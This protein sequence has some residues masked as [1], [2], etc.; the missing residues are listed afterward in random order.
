MAM[1]TPSIRISPIILDTSA[2]WDEWLSTIQACA[3]ARQILYLIDLT[4]AEQPVH[5]PKPTIPSYNEAVSQSPEGNPAQ[6]K[7][8]VYERDLYED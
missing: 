6:A 7:S 8:I 4:K 3:R 5:L 2:D 1:T